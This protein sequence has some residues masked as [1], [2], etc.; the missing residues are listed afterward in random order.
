MTVRM[1]KTTK[2]KINSFHDLKLAKEQV[3]VKII[4]N[5]YSIRDSHKN[6]I[7][8]LTPVNIFNSFIETIVAKPNVAIKAGYIIGSIFK[9]RS[10]KNKK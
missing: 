10:K 8:S 5:E 2:R 7:T 9:A 3:E 1:N 6:I 4:K